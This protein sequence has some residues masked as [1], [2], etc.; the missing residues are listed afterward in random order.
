MYRRRDLTRLPDELGFFVPRRE[1]YRILA[2]TFASEKF[3]SRASVGHVIVRAFQG[4]ALDPGAVDLDDAALSGRCHDDLAQLIGAGHPPLSTHVHRFQHAMPQF[5]VGHSSRVA[6]LQTEIARH[7]GLHIVGSG[8]GAY[9]LPDCVASGEEAAE[10]IALAHD[11]AG[12]AAPVAA[13][14]SNE[15]RDSAS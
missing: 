12:T 8:M 4:G 6:D 13:S 1:P 11:R 14:P 5:D 7:R 15:V 10:A 9:G 2:A 3:P